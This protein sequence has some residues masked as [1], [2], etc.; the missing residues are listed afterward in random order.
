[1][2]SEDKRWIA[3]RVKLLDMFAQEVA[4]GNFKKMPYSQWRTVAHN[5]SNEC[6]ISRHIYPEDESYWQY[7][8]WIRHPQASGYT[9]EAN[10]PYNDNGFGAFLHLIFE[11]SSLTYNK[12]AKDNMYDTTTSSNVISNS[13]WNAATTATIAI[14]NT[15]TTTG[16]TF[17]YGDNTWSNISPMT[18]SD[19]RRICNEI[20]NDKDNKKE[21]KRM[22]MFNFDFGPVS[23]NQFRMSPYGIAVHTQNNK[24]IAFNAKSGELFD[25]DILNFNVS[26]LIYKMPVALNAIAPGDIVIHNGNPMFV[27]SINDD[28][29]VSVIDY[30][31]ATISNILPVKSPFGFNFFTKICALFNFDQVNANADNPFGNMLPFLMLNGEK[32]GE[33]DP[34]LLLLASTMGN[35]AID[36]SKNPMLMMLL[37]DRKDKHDLLPFVL[38]MNSGMV[39][40]TV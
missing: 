10:F 40:P 22:N 28:G 35:G 34:T 39:T 11:K 26:K 37:M 18:E 29:T 19:V 33:F 5:T 24:W 15:V 14:P 6:V 2:H 31:N 13:G 3:D 21:E 16:Y 36:F 4:K 12:E 30:T 9:F 25:V 38:M 17:S 32:D 20:I 8:V 1:M 7:E 23:N 27:R